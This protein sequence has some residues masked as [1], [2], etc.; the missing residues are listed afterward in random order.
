[1]GF[2]GKRN[3]WDGWWQLANC[4][5]EDR[6]AR[7]VQKRRILKCVI[8]LPKAGMGKEEARFGLTPKNSNRCL[9]GSHRIV[10]ELSH[11]T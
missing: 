7:M 8:T 3:G 4:C 9:G 11:D 6:N 5:C 10:A 2:P 1:M